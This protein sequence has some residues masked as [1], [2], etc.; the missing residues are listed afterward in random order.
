MKTI[1]RL[2]ILG[3]TAVAVAAEHPDR[4]PTN[5]QH[6]KKSKKKTHQH[7]H[8]HV[9]SVP[10]TL[11]CSTAVPPWGN[12]T[13]VLT[14]RL[15]KGIRYGFPPITSYCIK[16]GKRADWASHSPHRSRS[17]RS[18]GNSCCVD[19]SERRKNESQPLPVFEVPFHSKTT[20]NGLGATKNRRGHG[21]D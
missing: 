14:L 17:C 19:L 15:V 12:A 5:E 7:Q 20:A 10:N 4:N 6:E 2:T 1:R 8:Q 9:E 3:K 13:P 18:A 11:L 21:E 16:Y